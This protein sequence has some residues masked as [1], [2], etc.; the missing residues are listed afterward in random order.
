MRA[1]RWTA[2]NVLWKCSY[3]FGFGIQ[4]VF[5]AEEINVQPRHY[6]NKT[7]Y[8]PDDMGSKKWKMCPAM[9]FLFYSNSLKD[10][11]N[12]KHSTGPIIFRFVESVPI[13]E[14]SLVSGTVDCGL[15]VWEEVQVKAEED[16]D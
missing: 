13:L 11:S 14:W 9:F 4:D 6:I 12:L 7:V 15:N 3:T 2:T 8:V 10:Y 5:Y 16:S 1:Y